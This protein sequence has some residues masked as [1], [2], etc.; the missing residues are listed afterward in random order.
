MTLR[1]LESAVVN[2]AGQG[3]GVPTSR[4]YEQAGCW[5]TESAVSHQHGRMAA[6]WPLLLYPSHWDMLQ[7]LLGSHTH[8]SMCSDGSHRS[9]ANTCIQPAKQRAVVG[10]MR[11]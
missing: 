9:L 11:S 5:V 8:H 1:A 3:G 7:V 10:G 4:L 6:V 2:L